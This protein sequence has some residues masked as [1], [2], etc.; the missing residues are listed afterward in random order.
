MISHVPL[1]FRLLLQ[2]LNTTFFV[3]H[4]LKKTSN[5]LTSRKCLI[6]KKSTFTSFTFHKEKHDPFFSF[7]YTIRVS[8]NINFP[9]QSSKVIHFPIK[10][11][12]SW[13]FE[14]HGNDTVFL[15]VPHAC[16]N[17]KLNS[18]SNS[19]LKRCSVLFFVILWTIERGLL[20]LNVRTCYLQISGSL[21]ICTRFGGTKDRCIFCSW[22]YVLFP[23]FQLHLSLLLRFCC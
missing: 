10:P 22:I 23:Y 12:S 19:I 2:T 11:T 15:F 14:T 13:T 9:P 1:L 5:Y 20:L 4:F 16:F 21:P 17:R 6:F 18:V 7:I 3:L 8:K